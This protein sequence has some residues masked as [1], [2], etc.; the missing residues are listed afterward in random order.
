M[1]KKK[2][3]ENI[4]NNSSGKS[5]LVAALDV[6]TNK[7]VCLIAKLESNKREKNGQKLRI[8]GFGH[9]MSTGVQGGTI[10]DL[11]RAEMAIRSTVETAEREAG[12]NI[13]S[14]IVNLGAP[15]LQ[16]RLIAFDVSI[17]GHKVSELDL[18]RIFQPANLESHKKLNNEVIHTIPVGFS[19]DGNRGIRDPRGMYGERLGV[20]LHTIS[21]KKGPIRNLETIIAQ[22]HLEI[23]KIVV[24][25]FASA[26]ACLVDDEKQVGAT[27]I[28][29][30]AGTTS[31]SIFFDG[32]LVFVD[33]IPLG[34]RNITSDIAKGIATSMSNA[35]RMKVCFGNAIPSAN[36]DHEIIKVPSE[37]EDNSLEDIQITRSMLI[38]II[39]P[40]LE[41]IVEIL[42][43]RIK[44]AGF[45]KVA[46]RRAVICGGGSQ[47]PGLP[48]LLG[49]HLNKQV[50][51]GKPLYIEG[52][53]ECAKGPEFATS[54]GLLSYSQENQN[55]ALDDFSQ[56]SSRSERGLGRLGQWFR[57][58]F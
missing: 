56:L 20:N 15:I 6:G 37:R 7:I 28:D 3:L 42:G 22:C 35:E 17:A 41:E 19:I 25:P 54:I 51:I 12:E 4:S 55:L 21:G 47:L 53:P 44:S 13:K 34:S 57:E 40:R 39:R 10:V 31:V 52:L 36:D 11:E 16:S 14:V 24:A 27:C 2:L 30:G 23:D 45:D 1:R 5:G 18:Q 58:N 33:S 32:E 50:R 46:G 48:E 29:V 8:V 49:R 26:L 38:G 9:Q 43:E